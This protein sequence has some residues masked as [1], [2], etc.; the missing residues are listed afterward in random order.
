MGK[1][2]IEGPMY[3]VK[4]CSHPKFSLMVKS[5]GGSQDHYDAMHPDWELDCQKNYV[6]YKVEDASKKIRGLWFHDD[7]ERR[8]VEAVLERILGQ[9]GN[10][11]ADPEPA[12]Q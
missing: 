11:T 10:G 8:K 3:V 1:A 4:R 9:L 12:P 5:Q 2:N 7:N 6:F